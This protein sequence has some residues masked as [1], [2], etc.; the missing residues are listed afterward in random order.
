M[1]FETLKLISKALSMF[2]LKFRY[3]L[4][5]LNTRTNLKIQIAL[6]YCIVAS[7]CKKI[8]QNVYIGK[9]VSLKNMENIELG[10]NVS[11]HDM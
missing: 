5:E 9:H 11:I 3:L 8:G 7:L 1:V 6:R 4:Y 2:P 10:N